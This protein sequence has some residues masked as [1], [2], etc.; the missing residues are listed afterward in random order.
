[1]T[2]ASTGNLSVAKTF[3]SSVTDSSGLD[4]AFP[5]LDSGAPTNYFSVLIVLITLTKE[6]SMFVNIFTSVQS[7]CWEE[8]VHTRLKTSLMRMRRSIADIRISQLQ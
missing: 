7:I 6:S 1:M 2:S 3:R 4:M 8:R 5:S